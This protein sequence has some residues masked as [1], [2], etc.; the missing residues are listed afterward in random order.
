MTKLLVLSIVLLV[1]LS[2]AAQAVTLTGENP[3]LVKV[4][5]R[6]GGADCPKNQNCI[7]R[8]VF[9]F[10]N[11]PLPTGDGTLTVRAD[12]DLGFLKDEPQN[13]PENQIDF[14]SVFKGN[15]LVPGD[16]LSKDLFRTTVSTCPFFAS[17]GEF[18]DTGGFLIDKDGNRIK[19]DGKDQPCGP[20]FHI[21]ALVKGQFTEL[22]EGDTD[23]PVA[24]AIGESSITITKANLLQ[25]VNA[26]NGTITVT[27]FP[28]PGT[29]GGE[30][31]GQ[32]DY[33]GV[34]LT[35]PTPAGN[36]LSLMWIGVLG[37]IAAR[38]AT[39]G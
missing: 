26:G 22:S 32:I 15:S 34:T 19:K 28:N 2:V 20:D 6:D 4:L 8:E 35:Y 24:E 37:L 1:G 9:T 16:L 33:I 36:S 18:V 30:G 3:D 17:G 31:V 12:G 23:M 11:A 25:L 38:F 10:K 14:V 21:I 27:L 39:R 29:A 7:K 13:V 5:A